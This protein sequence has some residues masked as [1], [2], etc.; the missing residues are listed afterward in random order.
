MS[1]Y[2]AHQDTGLFKIQSSS[3]YRALHGTGFFM[4][5]GA[6]CFGAALFMSIISSGKNENKE[7]VRLPYLPYLLTSL[8]SSLKLYRVFTSVKWMCS[9]ESAAYVTVFQ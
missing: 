4:V 7:S 6:A 8:F 2:K 3:W 1:W 9:D 5:Q